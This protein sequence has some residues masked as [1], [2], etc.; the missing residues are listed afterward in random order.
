MCTLST[1]KLRSNKK[2][3]RH[4]LRYAYSI[5]MKRIGLHLGLYD[6]NNDDDLVENDGS[7]TLSLRYGNRSENNQKIEGNSERKA[8]RCEKEKKWKKSGNKCA[9]YRNLAT[10]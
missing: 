4:I 5:R 9:R 6:N 3:C 1:P 10:L 2:G 8:E 7:G